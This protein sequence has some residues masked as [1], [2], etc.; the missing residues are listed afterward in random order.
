MQQTEKGNE[1]F[2]MKATQFQIIV[3]NAKA[4]HRLQ[5]SGAQSLFFHSWY[6]VTNWVYV[7]LSRVKTKS[8]LFLRK[9]L[10]NDLSKYSVPK[11]LTNMISKLRK[12]TAIF[13]TK[14]KMITSLTFL[15]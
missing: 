15:V 8:G 3:N 10:N 5:W 1:L 12:K 4:G 2:Y 7:I 14:N 11:K 13:H 9:Q 6:Y